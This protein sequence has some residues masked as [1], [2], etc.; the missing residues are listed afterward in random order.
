M[1]R[2]ARGVYQHI[3]VPGAAPQAHMSRMI[4]HTPVSV[5]VERTACTVPDIR[6][7]VPSAAK[8]SN[9]PSR[10][11]SGS[12]CRSRRGPPCSALVRCHTWHERTSSAAS[13][14]WPTGRVT[15]IPLG[16]PR[17]GRRGTGG[18]H[19]SPARRQQ[20]CRPLGLPPVV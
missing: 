12:G 5:A 15:A 3:G 10:D 6:R 2:R 8:R 7:I 16:P 18:A 11:G 17:A 13:P 14:S 9:P 20:G 1:L 4:A 19:A